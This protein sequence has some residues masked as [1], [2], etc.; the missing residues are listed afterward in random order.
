MFMKAREKNLKGRFKYFF[1]NMA[2]A[3]EKI[4]FSL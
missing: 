1:K 4:S 2:D 3:E